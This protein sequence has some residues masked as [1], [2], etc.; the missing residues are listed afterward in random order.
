MAA[1]EFYTAYR[2]AEIANCRGILFQY[3]TQAPCLGLGIEFDRVSGKADPGL[4]RC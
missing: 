2:Y 3:A 1:M 4:A